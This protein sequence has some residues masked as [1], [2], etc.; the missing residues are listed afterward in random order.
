M[1][2]QQQPGILA[3][4]RSRVRII[5]TYVAM[6][7]AFAIGPLLVAAMFFLQGISDDRAV[8]A[9]DIYFSILPVASAV[10]SY[11]FATRSLEQKPPS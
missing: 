8:M 11:W 3:Q 10:I 9:K 7:Y 6:F 4:R 5:V 2:D 1:A